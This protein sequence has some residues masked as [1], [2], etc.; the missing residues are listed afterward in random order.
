MSEKRAGGIRV[1]LIPEVY[2][3]LALPTRQN[4]EINRMQIN[5]TGS[6]SQNNVRY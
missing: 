5:S 4:F 1:G 2:R 3:N 6:L